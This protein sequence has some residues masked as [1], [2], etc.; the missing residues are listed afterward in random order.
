MPHWIE[1]WQQG[2]YASVWVKIPTIYPDDD[3][4][5]IKMYYNSLSTNPLRG[6]DIFPFFDDFESGSNTK[7]YFQLQPA[8]TIFPNAAEV[9]HTFSV[10][11]RSGGYYG[12]LGYLQTESG[13]VNKISVYT[14]SSLT[15]GWTLASTLNYNG[16]RWPSVI[17]DGSTYW[18]VHTLNFCN[19]GTKKI[20]LRSSTDGLSW[21]APTDVV[22][23]HWNPFLMKDP[24]S[25]NFYLYHY[26]D[27]GVTFT[28]YARSASS[29][30]GL[31]SA[32]SRAVI[33][34]NYAR[35]APSVLENKGVYYLT[36]ETLEGAVWRTRVFA[37]NMPDRGFYEV[38]FT[39]LGNPASGTACWFQHKFNNELHAYSCY[40]D[41]TGS[42]SVN[43]NL[44]SLTSFESIRSPSPTSWS[45]VES[46]G[47]W[48]VVSENPLYRKGSYS[49]NATTFVDTV[50][51]KQYNQYLLS[52]APFSGD[53]NVVVTGKILSGR[54]WGVVLGA[55]AAAS[56]FYSVNLYEDLDT[57]QNLW[58]YYWPSGSKSTASTVTSAAVGTISANT[59]YTMKIQV[60]GLS[61]TVDLFTETSP[62]NSMATVSATL[63]Q[64]IDGYIGLY[65][66]GNGAVA[67]FDNVYV[68]GSATLSTSVSLGPARSLPV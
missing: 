19:G 35:A 5:S 63:N 1:Y 22:L 59:W 54:V 40:Q 17:Q 46:G 30:S 47:V 23:G 37:S 44:G 26:Y 34:A 65:G 52:T 28:L 67:I 10:V 41:S 3:G 39:Y 56:P 62:L 2:T 6:K 24:F 31:P 58:I 33:Q 36:F 60:R 16:P 20:V 42:W 49:L 43:H 9:P 66:E 4:V 15:T 12:Y 27:D 50:A 68:V 53:F 51:R 14:S 48:T 45:A 25:G 13:C 55:T 11:E 64:S 57:S 8:T 38:D 7:G 32:T 18:M 21:S 61:L 29:P